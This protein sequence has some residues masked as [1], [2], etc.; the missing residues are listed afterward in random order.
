MSW[1]GPA[2]GRIAVTNASTDGL[3]LLVAA[4]ALTIVGNVVGAW[5]GIGQLTAFARVYRIARNTITPVSG[6]RRGG[7]INAPPVILAA[8][9]TA[10]LA[11]VLARILTRVLTVILHVNLGPGRLGRS[12]TD[13][14]CHDCQ[15]PQYSH[16]SRFRAAAE[17]KG[18]LV[19]T[20]LTLWAFCP[21]TQVTVERRLDSYPM[22]ALVSSQSVHCYS[23]HDVIPARLISRRRGSGT[24]SLRNGDFE[25]PR[26]RTYCREQHHREVNL[27]S[28]QP[29][30]ASA[31]GLAIS[32]P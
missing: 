8:K 12:K 24:V 28:C 3:G 19:A 25:R 32:C 20:F 1:D 31:A 4:P 15:N 14:A 22:G 7:L 13:H 11:A 2:R 9:L 16:G 26:L 17:F 27:C 21:H 30:L 5:S 10:D 18:I 6:R 23:S 29:S